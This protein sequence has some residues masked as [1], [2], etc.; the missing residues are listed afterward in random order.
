MNTL[1]VIIHMYL[2]AV[3]NSFE[4]TDKQG[5]GNPDC[6]VHTVNLEKKKFRFKRPI[7]TG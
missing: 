4:R 5:D 3:L 1:L 6:E 2:P 7:A